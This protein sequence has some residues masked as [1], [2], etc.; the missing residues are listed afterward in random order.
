MLYATLRIAKI[1]QHQALEDAARTHP[2]AGQP[3]FLVHLG[4]L[5]I[6]IGRRLQARHQYGTVLHAS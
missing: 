2:A 6:T 3:D 1:R 4:A 5:L